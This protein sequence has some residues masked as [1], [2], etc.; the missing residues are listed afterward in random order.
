MPKIHDDTPS[1]HYLS[2][3]KI[4]NNVNKFTFSTN[5][6]AIS[7]FLPIFAPILIVQTDNNVLY[8]RMFKKSL[9]FCM[10]MLCFAVTP[11]AQTSSMTDQQVMEY[12]EMGMQ[13]GKSQQQIATELARRGVTREQAERV[14]KQY[15]QKKQSG[16][17]MQNDANIRRTR[18]AEE[19]ELNSDKNYVGRDFNFDNGAETGTAATRVY[20]YVTTQEL[21]LAGKDS[22]NFTL[23]K[24]GNLVRKDMT[25]FK[26]ELP[27]DLIFG[28][29]IFNSSNL[30]FEP[31][32]NLP[33]PAN[34]KLGAGDEIIIDIWGA[35]QVAI[36][37]TLSPD[38]AINI[39][40][41]GLVF[42]NGMTINEATNYLRKELN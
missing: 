16:K 29:N 42:L 30:T 41:L 22:L 2:A 23:D 26:E 38:G 13:Q 24:N 17:T 6:D 9:I 20:K 8:S 28:R 39:E 4:E 37:Q 40:N 31:N 18:D 14:R 1:L 15:G 5:A 27:E 25:I 34:Y 21:D 36:Q 19:E 33:T 32:N 7:K 11:W 35:S 12:V 3:R 10:M